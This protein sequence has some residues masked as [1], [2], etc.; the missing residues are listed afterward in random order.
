MTMT[1]LAT[2]R[3]IDGLPL[4][5]NLDD[6]KFA[7][8][9]LGHHEIL[10]TQTIASSIANPDAQNILVDANMHVSGDLIFTEPNKYIGT[11]ASED[12]RIA[13][14]G[15]TRMTITEEGRV[16]IGTTSPSQRLHVTQ[17]IRTDDRYYVGSHQGI[18][19]T[20]N[21]RVEY[22]NPQGH[23]CYMDIRGGIITAQ[24][25]N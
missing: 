21:N 6:L 17:G 1:S 3:G 16:G 9:S 22:R 5:G 10:Y 19:R 25:C 2:A 13:T 14:S 15:Q 11:R 8:R 7:A 20:S 4:V 24:N 18:D 23:S 12:F